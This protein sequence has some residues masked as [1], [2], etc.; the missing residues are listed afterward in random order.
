MHAKLLTL[1]AVAPLAL[2]QDWLDDA[3]NALESTT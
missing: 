3:M 2:G 1:L